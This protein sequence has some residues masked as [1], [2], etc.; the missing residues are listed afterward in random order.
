MQRVLTVQAE[1]GVPS[2]IPNSITSR[3]NSIVPAIISME[4]YGLVYLTTLRI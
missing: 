1:A 2:S 4:R 3:K